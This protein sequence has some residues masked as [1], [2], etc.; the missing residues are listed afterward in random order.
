M[1][2][3]GDT[4]ESFYDEGLT[5][6]MKGDM[7]T[8]IHYFEKAVRLD[9]SFLA[10]RHQLGKA[11]ARMGRGEEA[12][13]LLGEVVARKPD[14]LVARLDLG[15]ALLSVGRLQEARDQFNAVV[16]AEPESPRGYLGLAQT[17]FEEGHWAA[18]L[19]QA[20]LALSHG[21]QGFQV[22]FM[23]GRA[24]RLAGSPELAN[25]SLGQSERLLEQSIELSPDQPEG[26]F[27]RG[28]VCFVRDQFP[29]ALDHY[30]AAEART[31]AKRVYSAFGES[32]SLVDVLARQGVCYQRL[33]QVRRAAEVA[34]RILAIDPNHKLALSFK[35]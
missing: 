3:G 16:G 6:G 27:F 19:A 21:G 2:F 8:A 32:F 35:Q 26:Y 10:A 28:E 15:A 31:D 25:E 30:R 9:R 24:A 23:I 33:G 4:A 1:A 11:Y 12:V 18:A 20:Q 17:F 5:A 7:A 13:N 34:D 14:N 29:A 22:L